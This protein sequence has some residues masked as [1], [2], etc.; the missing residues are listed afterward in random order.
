M[1]FEWD[2]RK[3]ASNLRKHGVDFEIAKEVF[4]DLFA[5]DALDPL[6]DEYGEDRFVI[7]GFGGGKLLTVTYTERG[8]TTRLISA[9][10]ATRTEHDDYQSANP[11]I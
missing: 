8:E 4:T 3:A 5:L 6:S 2:A 11:Q 1:A 9:R 10:K 7:T